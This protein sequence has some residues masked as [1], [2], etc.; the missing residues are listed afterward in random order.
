MHAFDE[1]V[2]DVACVWIGRSLRRVRFVEFDFIR[3]IIEF[4]R[5]RSN[6]GDR[7]VEVI[8]RTESSQG[9]GTGDRIEADHEQ[10]I[11]RV[12]NDVGRKIEFNG[13]PQVPGVRRVGG[14]IERDVGGADVADFDEFIEDI[15]GGI[16]IRG[17]IHDFGDHNGPNHGIRIG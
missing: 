16:D 6:D 5:V 2:R 17:M 11:G 8:M 13:I 4:A 14:M 3:A 9:E 10:V 15:I 1:D 12:H 7:G